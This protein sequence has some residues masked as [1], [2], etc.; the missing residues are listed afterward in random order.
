LNAHEDTRSQSVDST[1]VACLLSISWRRRKRG[2]GPRR[3]IQR[4]T[5]RKEEY[6]DLPCLRH[7]ADEGLEGDGGDDE[8][9]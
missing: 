4:R 6:T 1:R 8:Q 3:R 2:R 7:D 9:G 5:I